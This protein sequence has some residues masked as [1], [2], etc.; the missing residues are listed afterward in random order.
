MPVKDFI[1]HIQVDAISFIITPKKVCF[2]YVFFFSYTSLSF[3]VFEAS[4]FFRRTDCAFCGHILQQWVLPTPRG[5]LLR[6][7][8]S[9]PFDKVS[10]LPHC[11]LQC[12]CCHTMNFSV[13]NSAND[14]TM[15][16]AV[17]SG[18]AQCEFVLYCHGGFY[19]GNGDYLPN[20]VIRREIF[21][22]FHAL[23]CDD[24]QIV[25]VLL[26]S[27]FMNQLKTL[28]AVFYHLCSLPTTNIRNYQELLALTS[29]RTRMDREK[30]THLSSHNEIVPFLHSSLSQ[31]DAMD[32]DCKSE[33]EH[34]EEPK[35]SPMEI[36]DAKDVTGSKYVRSES[37]YVRPIDNEFVPFNSVLQCD[38]DFY[39]FLGKLSVMSLTENKRLHLPMSPILFKKLLNTTS[40][41][42]VCQASQFGFEDL[43][44]IHPNIHYVS[45]FYRLLKIAQKKN[46]YAMYCG[47]D[48]N[49]GSH[50]D[51]SEHVQLRDSFPN[52]QDNYLTKWYEKANAWIESLYLMCDTPL[53]G[54]PLRECRSQGLSNLNLQSLEPYLHGIIEFY[55]GY[56][57]EKQISSIIHGMKTLWLANSFDPCFVP[58]THKEMHL[59]VNGELF[60]PW[61][62]DYLQK[63]VR[64]RSSQLSSDALP[65]Q[66]DTLL[67]KTIQLLFE[68]LSE[69]NQS[70]QSKFI[71]FLTASPSLPIG[72]LTALDPPFTISV[73]QISSNNNTNE[74]NMEWPSTSTCQ[75]T[76]RLTHMF[77]NKE[78]LKEKLLKAMDICQTGFISIFHVWDTVP[79]AKK[80]LFCFVN[81]IIKTT[82]GP[83][84][85]YQ[86]ND[87]FVIQKNLD[88]N[89]I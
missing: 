86:Y 55:F 38:D 4:F 21:S 28:A 13:V 77:Q 31:K 88:P 65:N 20:Q 14:S 16:S 67:N 70:Q 34:K 6:A 25:P 9:F 19:N 22:P 64:I 56:G 45:L 82:V 89:P 15:R 27:Q 44:Y 42:N 3:F 30:M 60:K 84:K 1:V 66:K 40:C 63:N 26:T 51:T 61:N 75:H 37:I 10:C 35:P 49:R 83:N 23:P 71:R 52:Y 54:L 78:I 85:N 5:A 87:M 17:N 57:V 76:L 68:I 48:S 58:F 24:V 39:E 18:Q 79:F 59:M 7:T 12:R 73:S 46:H 29:A 81:L 69:L 72:G 74:A 32:L 50:N 36:D 41:N 80:S 47:A 8:N 2:A 33:L 11:I 53:L 43:L 62:I